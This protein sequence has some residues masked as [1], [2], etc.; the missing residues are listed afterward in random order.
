VQILVIGDI[1]GRPG[2]RAVKENIPDLSS[3]FELDF[4]IANGENAAGGNGLTREVVKELFS[5]GID[6]LT[7][8]NHA[9]DQKDIFNFITTEERILRPANF[10]PGVPG[11]GIN[12]YYPRKKPAVGV[13]NLAGR[14]F[15]PH[16]D[17]P[18]RKV[19][20]LLF[21]LKDQT[22][23]IIIDFHGE[24]TS[25]KIALGWYI[26]GRASAVCGTHTHVQTADERILPEGTAFISDLG[27]T[28][29]RDSVI[30]V[31][32]EI[33]IKRFLTQLPVRLEVAKGPYQFNAV[34]IKVDEKTGKAEEID[35]IYNN[36]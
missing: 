10:P 3:R 22:K 35:R 26:D 17:C 23:V 27:M 6:V 16:L 34:L 36:E 7:T 19:D 25:E 29:P 21:Q 1:V 5:Y 15:M 2:R 11:R 28:G 13:I 14:V 4:I 24:A 32:K 18:F 31:K 30:G 9:W 33:I 8:G 12:I 20:E